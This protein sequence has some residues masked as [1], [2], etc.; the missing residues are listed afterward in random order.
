MQESFLRCFDKYR[1]KTINS[2]LLY[3]IARNALID[4]RRRDRRK[5][6]LKKDVADQTADQENDFRV[7]EKYRKVL[8]AMKKLESDEREIL[9]L[10][11]TEDMKYKE[12]ASIMGINEGNVKVRVHRARLKLKEL[13]QENRHE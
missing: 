1:N 11:L 9:A 13:L 4:F 2:S 3:K 10:V 6:S 8:T 7:K 5:D 12:I